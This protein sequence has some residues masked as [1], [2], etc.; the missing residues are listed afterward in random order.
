M[1]SE[2][3]RLV[4]PFPEVGPRMT[5][6]YGQLAAATNGAGTIPPNTRLAR[7]WDPVS[8]TDP[9]LR[10]EVWEWLDQVVDWINTE[11][12]WAVDAAIPPCWPLHP[13]L[14]HDLAT[15]AD[16]RR[17]AASAL[18]SDPLEEWH[19][20]ALPAFTDRMKQRLAGSCSNDHQAAPGTGRRFRYRD[21]VTRG[22]VA[23]WFGG[24]C[25]L[26]SQA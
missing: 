7:P 3:R 18:T 20:Y 14:V 17:T 1:T 4:A 6:A 9:V 10:L 11:H 12:T 5:L 24:D 19:R 25:L 21:P 26:P 15:L 13:H 2:Q 23:R 16:Q 8:C 22:Q